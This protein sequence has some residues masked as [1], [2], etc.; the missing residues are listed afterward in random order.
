MKFFLKFFAWSYLHKRFRWIYPYINLEF[1]LKWSR[2]SVY[3]NFDLV[4][5]VDIDEK[6][7]IMTAKITQ[8]TSLQIESLPWDPEEYNGTS[9]LTVPN[10]LFWQPDIC[11]LEVDIFATRKIFRSYS[12]ESVPIESKQRASGPT[13]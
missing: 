4:Q 10:T 11:K 5:I 6:N 7:G 1:P 13:K 12:A 9:H 3:V 2:F 8:A